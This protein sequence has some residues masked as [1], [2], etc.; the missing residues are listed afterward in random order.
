M[1][2]DGTSV[3]KMLSKNPKLAA[4]MKESGF[5]YGKKEASG[6]TELDSIMEEVK[7]IREKMEA[8]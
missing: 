6:D 5:D 3:S 1:Y 4:L 2:G 7:Q 8:Q